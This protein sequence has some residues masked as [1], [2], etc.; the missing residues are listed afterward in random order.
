MA[1]TEVTQLPAKLP[2]NMDQAIATRNRK[3]QV[4]HFMFTWGIFCFEIMIRRVQKIEKLRSLLFSTSNETEYC[5][6]T[7]SWSFLRE[8]ATDNYSNTQFRRLKRDICETH[9]YSNFFCKKSLIVWPQISGHRTD[10][11]I[12]FTAILLIS[13]QGFIGSRIQ[14]I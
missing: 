13:T 12:E 5:D 8:Q 10:K 1:R 6:I 4:L 3:I 9:L 2:I 7:F 11:L 14:F